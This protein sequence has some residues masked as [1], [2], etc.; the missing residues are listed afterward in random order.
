MSPP[1]DKTLAFH[2]QEP[3]TKDWL[4]NRDEFILISL[5][6]LAYSQPFLL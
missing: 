4:Q 1:L 5:D 6:F 3:A 2:E